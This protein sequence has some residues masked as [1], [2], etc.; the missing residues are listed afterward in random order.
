MAEEPPRGSCAIKYVWVCASRYKCMDGFFSIKLCL[1][2]IRFSLTFKLSDSV[3]LRPFLDEN[4][5]V[6]LVLCAG[7]LKGGGK[8]SSLQHLFLTKKYHD[9]LVSLDLISFLCLLISY[10]HHWSKDL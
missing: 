9:A 6:T 8:N 2:V 10:W 5:E 7:S 1:V 3:G 4:D